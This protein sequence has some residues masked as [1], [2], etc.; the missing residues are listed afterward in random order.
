MEHELL[1]TGDAVIYE[2]SPDDAVWE[3]E[4]GAAARIIIEVRRE[5]RNY[6]AARAAVGS[7]GSGGM[8]QWTWENL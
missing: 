1:R 8:P 2:D 6:W 3:I 5:I 7:G 4:A